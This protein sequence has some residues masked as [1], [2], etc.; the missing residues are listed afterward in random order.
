MGEFITAE[1]RIVAVINASRDTTEANKENDPETKKEAKWE[2]TEASIR[3]GQE[4]MEAVHEKRRTPIN[5][6]HSILDLGTRWK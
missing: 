3:A 4:K 1:N 2:K 5:S 6:S